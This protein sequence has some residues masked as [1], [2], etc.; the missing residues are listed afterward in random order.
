MAA[1][2]S[3]YVVTTEGA[4]CLHR[5]A[6]CI[7]SCATED[8]CVLHHVCYT[9]ATEDATCLHTY[10]FAYICNTEPSVYTHVKTQQSPLYILMCKHVAFSALTTYIEPVAAIYIWLCIYSCAT[11]WRLMREGTE[12]D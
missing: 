11:M 2:G 7:Y 1:T 8:A 4:T 5:Y 6:L 10:M 12:H 3:I 9:C